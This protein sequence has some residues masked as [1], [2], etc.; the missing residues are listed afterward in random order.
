M[1]DL[2]PGVTLRHHLS[3][4]TGGD[5]MKHLREW[6]HVYVLGALVVFPEVWL[7]SPELQALL[8]A[9]LVSTVGPYIGGLG[10]AVQLWKARAKASDKPDPTDEAGA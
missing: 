7:H 3:N 8:P 6:F 5:A 2:Q 10:L 9:K 1:T 4:F